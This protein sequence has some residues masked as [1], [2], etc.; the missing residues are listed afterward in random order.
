MRLTKV[1]IGSRSSTAARHKLS[2]TIV[3]HYTLSH[4]S[5]DLPVHVLFATISLSL[6][7]LHSVGTVRRLVLLSA[8]ALL[9]RTSRACCRE[10]THARLGNALAISDILCG[11][12]SPLGL[13]LCC[14][15]GLDVDGCLRLAH[16]AARFLLRDYVVVL[17]LVP[18][19]HNVLDMYIIRS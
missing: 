11:L 15:F 19:R 12:L 9:S 3:R 5:T 2:V 14:G 13:R 6:P 7:A 4:L 16:L 10:T 18:A 17:T 8:I 1:A